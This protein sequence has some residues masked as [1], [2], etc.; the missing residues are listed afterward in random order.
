[1][2]PN[3]RYRAPSDVRLSVCQEE[4]SVRAQDLLWMPLLCMWFLTLVTFT[5][6][7]RDGPE[8]IGS[9]DLVAILKLLVRLLSLAVLPLALLRA[10]DRPRC[11]R[12]IHTMLPLGLFVGW[13][14]VSSAWSALP[15]VSL[16]QASS[17]LVLSLLALT[18]GAVWQGPEDTSRI[19]RH[20]SLALLVVSSLILTV[21]L[22]DHRLSGLGH[23]EFENLSAVGIVTPTAAGA[24]ASLGLVLALCTRYMWNW[25]WT[26]TLFV[27]AVMI[28]TALLIMAVSRTYLALGVVLS[29]LIL[30]I[31]ANRAWFSLAV[32]AGATVAGAYLVIDPNQEM[33]AT[34]I[35]SVAVYSG[36]GESAETLGA[37]NGRTELWE[38]VLKEISNSPVIGHGY[39]VTS[40]SG[41]LDVWEG[42][43]NRTAHNVILQ[44]VSTT[45]VVGLLLFIWGF[46]RPIRVAVRRLSGSAKCDAAALCA[47]ALVLGCWY[48][49][50][51]LMNDSFMGPVSPEAVGFFATLGVLLGAMPLLREDMA[52]EP[53][54]RM[55]R[56]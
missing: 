54:S 35:G 48:F 2:T 6:P 42:P 1:V 25:P 30:L 34:A 23:G 26:R 7:G 53:D 4:R 29:A 32:L 39:F 52:E 9:L 17:L 41:A 27:P 51:G 43:Q 46:G 37:L 24:A 13:S 55:V 38:A 21:D 56:R 33:F 22:I 12:A 18:I 49:G 10:W 15:A 47:L 3:G 5:L 31:Y 16:G 11:R 20:V 14:I 44:V 28:H 8:S 40:A 36:R 50:S 19:L 45:G